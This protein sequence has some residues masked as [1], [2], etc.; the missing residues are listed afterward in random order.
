[1]TW[2]RGESNAASS[3]AGR[4]AP[5]RPER[6][7]RRWRLMVVPAPS[8]GPG[9]AAARRPST[10]RTR[11]W[12]WEAP[13]PTVPE[14]LRARPRAAM[15]SGAATPTRKSPQPETPFPRVMPRMH[16]DRRRPLGHHLD[17]IR[18]H[19]QDP[20]N[21][22]PD[23]TPFIIELHSVLVDPDKTLSMPLPKNSHRRPPAPS[24]GQASPRRPPMALPT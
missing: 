5:V 7:I 16:H 8:L 3:S 18:H 17:R 6:P 21:E 19:Q 9:L 2:A 15:S 4:A 10:S 14:R 11:P 20:H 23:Q 13:C 24:P 12:P 22:N 1:M